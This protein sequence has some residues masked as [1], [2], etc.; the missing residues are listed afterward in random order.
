MFHGK[1]EAMK[2]SCRNTHDEIRLA[3]TRTASSTLVCSRTQISDDFP[4]YKKNKNAISTR[5]KPGHGLA[6]TLYSPNLYPL[7]HRLLSSFRN[8]LLRLLGLRWC[9]WK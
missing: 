6:S 7:L 5:N 2:A 3:A 9:Y 1:R 8:I 4:N